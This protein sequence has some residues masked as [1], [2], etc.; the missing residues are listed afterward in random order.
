MGKKGAI[1]KGEMG[2]LERSTRGSNQR[3]SWEMDDLTS[4]RAHMSVGWLW[5]LYFG[6]FW[7]SGEAWSR[8]KLRK[9]SSLWFS[10]V[11]E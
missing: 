8:F 7:R 4:R 6:R 1:Y 10:T 5:F 2:V 11:W 9:P 3:G